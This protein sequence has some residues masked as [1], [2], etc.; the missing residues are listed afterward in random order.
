[1]ATN[2]YNRADS[3]E[4]AKKVSRKIKGWYS[5]DAFHDKA[6]DRIVL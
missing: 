4:F 3:L 6:V 2:N 1:M 5:N